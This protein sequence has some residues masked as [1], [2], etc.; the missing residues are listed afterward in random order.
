MA[1]F[2]MYARLRRAG[3][4]AA[5][6]P[7][8]LS[9]L[10]VLNYHINVLQQIDVSQYVAARIASMGS[11]ANVRIPFNFDERNANVNLLARS[12]RLV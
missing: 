12:R 7:V 11:K 5:C 8:L 1:N 6:G 9:S 10:A 2:M 3:R 4:C